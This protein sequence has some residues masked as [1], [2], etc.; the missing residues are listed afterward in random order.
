[1]PGMWHDSEYLS[2]RSDDVYDETGLD[3]LERFIADNDDTPTNQSFRRRFALNLT[4]PSRSR[5]LASQSCAVLVSLFIIFSV[6]AVS[7]SLGYYTW[8]VRKP[9]I[10]LD[11]SIEA[12]NI[13]NHKA[14]IRFD[15][16][17]LARRY[18][19]T[20]GRFK[21]DLGHVREPGSSL[22]GSRSLGRLTDSLLQKTD[23]LR[24]NSLSQD[25]LFDKLVKTGFLTREG[26]ETEAYLKRLS[27]NKINVI[28]KRSLTENRHRYRSSTKCALG[29]QVFPRWKMQVIFLA[30]GN[31]DLNMFTKE[32]LETVHHVEKK[33]ITHPRFPD[34]CLKLRDDG[35]LD[36]AVKANRGCAPLNSLMT[37]FF[38]SED[39]HGA[40][41]FDG[42]GNNIIDIG[43]ALTLAMNHNTFYYYVDEKINRTYH[44]SKLLRTE[45][46]FGEPLQGINHSASRLPTGETAELV[47]C[48]FF[49]ISSIS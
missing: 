36:P 38:P 11:K 43:S 30:Q 49:L 46:V 4:L 35:N 1:M 3:H 41:Y 9:E 2:V 37:Y 10:V 42:L 47:K 7:V 14:Y 16:F 26:E 17:I 6:A 33:I 39:N 22:H 40:V 48:C 25:E 13:P 15:A 23:T 12:F 24:Q 44:H 20:R 34:F 31:S 18:N 45:V 29:Y 5:I 8:K 21:R 19:S 32:R 27:G 28:H